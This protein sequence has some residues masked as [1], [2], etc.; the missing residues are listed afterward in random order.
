[1]QFGD[2]LD[3]DKFDAYQFDYCISNPPFGIDWKRE[4]AAVEAEHKKG[5][6][7]RFSPGLPSKSDGQMLFLLN[8]LSN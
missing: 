2:T 7:G 1:M 5:A 4:A 3:D 6:A 8:G